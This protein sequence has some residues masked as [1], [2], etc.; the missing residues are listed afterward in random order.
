MHPASAF[1]VQ[2]RHASRCGENPGSPLHFEPSYRAA[3]LTRHAAESA[4]ELTAR[5]HGSSQELEH[6][7]GFIEAK[8]CVGDALA[9]GE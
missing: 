4:F 3:R 7:N 8:A 6:R 9:V 5:T 1:G 2:A